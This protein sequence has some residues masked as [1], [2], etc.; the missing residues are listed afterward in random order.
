MTEVVSR[1]HRSTGADWLGAALRAIDG[2]LA[3]CMGIEEFCAEPQCIIRIRV[4]LA[5]RDVC[6][7]GEMPIRQGNPIGE[8][9]LWNEHLPA[10][11]E[12]GSA[13]AWALEIRRRFEFSFMCLASSLETDPRLQS[14]QGFRGGMTFA[15]GMQ[16]TAK[17]RR[18]MAWYGIEIMPDEPRRLVWLR[19]FGNAL[20][21]LA[22]IC[23]YHPSA[24]FGGYRLQR[25]RHELWLSRRVLCERYGHLDRTERVGADGSRG[26]RK[27]AA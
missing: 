24:S 6:L 25:R 7:A 4:A 20:F 16:R 14:L 19:D 22:L 9:H 26:K 12:Y 3:R 27:D 8:L 2:I 5:D 21:T 10:I 13:L 18:V 15:Y 1:K 11:S 17:L 23:A